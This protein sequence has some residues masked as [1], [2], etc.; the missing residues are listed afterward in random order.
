M[1]KGI[2]TL[3][4]SESVKL[5]SVYDPKHVMYNAW[6]TDVFTPDVREELEEYK[7]IMRTG[8]KDSSVINL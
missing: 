7:Q 5:P 6:R 1:K 8:I 2:I 4:H 3:R